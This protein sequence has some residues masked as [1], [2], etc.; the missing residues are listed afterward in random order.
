MDEYEILED[1]MSLEQTHGVEII[2]QN[3]PVAV[4]SQKQSIRGKGFTMVEDEALCRAYLAISQD[5]IIGTNQTMANLW[6][7]I[8]LCFSSQAD[9]DCNRTAVSLM[10]RWSKIQKAMAEAKRMFSIDERNKSFMFESCWE[11][12]RHS[13]KWDEIMTPSQKPT[14]QTTTSSNPSTGTPISLESK[15]DLDQQPSREGVN[16]PSGIKAALESRRKKSR[17]QL[18]NVISHYSQHKIVCK[19]S[20]VKYM[21]Y[22]FLFLGTYSQFHSSNGDDPQPTIDRFFNLQD[23]LAQT[24]LVVQ[25]LTNITPLRTSDT[26]INTTGSVKEVLNLAVERKKNATSWIKSDFFVSPVHWLESDS[27]VVVIEWDRFGVLVEKPAL[28]IT[29]V[30]LLAATVY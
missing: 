25:S 11:I 7:R 13:C 9:V 18:G 10:K 29:T 26:D 16:R 30:R 8:R 2:S 28:H 5:P 24:R 3:F 12:L 22:M 19:G 23:D 17:F 14:V 27:G 15:L 1:S 4:G 20:G 21:Y 6:E